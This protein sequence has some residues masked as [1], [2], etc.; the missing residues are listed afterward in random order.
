MIDDIYTSV[1]IFRER[2]HA[3]LLAQSLEN[4]LVIGSGSHGLIHV[5]GLVLSDS[6]SCFECMRGRM[7][8]FIPCPQREASNDT[9]TQVSSNFLNL[10][11]FEGFLVV[12]ARYVA[13]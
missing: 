12:Y 11:Q 10:V 3:T 7:W 8:L 4:C 5:A 13:I 6:R 9:M 2:S 1:L